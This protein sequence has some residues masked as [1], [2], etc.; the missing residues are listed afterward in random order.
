MKL[1]L[2]PAP[3]PTM[4]LM[5]CARRPKLGFTLIE[6]LVA[7]ALFA[8]VSAMTFQGLH[9]SM[10][11]QEATEDRFHDFNEVQLVWTLML[12]DFT[13]LAR[14]PIRN[15]YGTRTYRAFMPQGDGCAISFTR[16]TPF[17]RSGMQR[18]AYCHE[19]DG[20]YRR[21]WSSLDRPDVPEYREALLTGDVDDFIVE[22]E[23]LDA[24]KEKSP[25]HVFEQLPTHIEVTL[26][27]RDKEYT[28]NFPGLSFYDPFRDQNR[29]TKDDDKKEDDAKEDDKE[30]AKADDKADD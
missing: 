5:T 11:V 3:K 28:R 14:R 9:L 20:L 21:V 15:R 13:H 10:T 1:T 8:L 29:S 7:M 23:G 22:A 12:R 16:Y 2:K 17:S 6:V 19:E 18:I 27:V 24:V 4:Q 30:D 25:Q 26:V